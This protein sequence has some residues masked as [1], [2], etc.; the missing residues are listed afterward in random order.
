MKIFT[1]TIAKEI[2]K[3]LL[4]HKI[5]I[6][7]E[8]EIK[9]RGIKLEKYCV[10]LEDS[11]LGE[12]KKEGESYVINIQALDHYYR[13]RFTM[14]HE[15]GHFELHKDLLGDGVDETK[16]YTRLY[17]RNNRI[18]ISEEVEANKYAADKLMPELAIKE[19][20]SLV[21]VINKDGEID[22]NILDYLYKKFQVSKTALAN[23]L[24]TLFKEG[25]LS[26]N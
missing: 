6:N 25:K 26:T 22:L 5:P 21:Q 16:E 2:G 24:R 23:R 1:D 14:A 20:S 15:L 17:R 7:I 10:D 19:V 18:S 3:V 4:K 12:I 8:E 11:V 13:K 9:G